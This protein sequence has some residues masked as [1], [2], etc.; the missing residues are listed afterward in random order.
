MLIISVGATAPG[1]FAGDRIAPERNISMIQGELESPQWKILW[2]KAREFVRDENYLFA[3]NAYAQ[4]YSLK[5]NIEEANWEYCKVLLKVDD[6]STA[7]KIVGDLI[8][9][10]PNNSQY[11][12]TGGAVALHWKNYAT[13]I[14]YYGRVLEKDPNGANSDPA[15][16]GLATSL[17]DQG[18]KELAFTLFEQY[19]LRHPENHAVIRTLAD[20]A[21]SLGKDD[22]AR[23]LYSQLLENPSVGDQVIFQAVQVFDGPGY[24]KKRS[25]LWQEYLNRHPDYIPFRQKLAQYYMDAGAFEAALLQVKYLVDNSQNNDHFLLTAG[26]IS[27][28]DLHRPDR[29]LFFYERYLQKHPEDGGVKAKISEIQSILAADFLRI[30]EKEGAEQLWNDLADITLDR[31]AMYLE[32]ADLLEKKGNHEQLIDVLTTLFKHSARDDDI[33]LRLAEQYYRKALYKKT[34]EY[35][36]LV[37]AEKNKSK[38]YY[39]MKGDAEQHLGLEIK[40]LASYERSLAFD[41]H[42]FA[43]REKCLLL[44]GKIGNGNKLKSF[45][46]GGLYQTD[47]G[48]LSRFV[49][50]YLDLL[51]Y[52]F[53][54]EEYARTC[55]WAKERFAGWP[56]ITTRIDLHMAGSLRK[57]GKTKRAEQLLRQLLLGN[58]FVEDVLFQLAEDAVNDK[59]VAGAKSW[60]QELLKTT[61]QRDAKFSYDPHGARLLLVRVEMLQAEGEY[62]EAQQIIDLYLTAAGK[63]STQ[64][65][66][67]P[68]LVALEKKHCWL[69]YYRG[70]VREAYRQC[71][72]LLDNGPFDPELITLK[73]LLLGKLKKTDDGTGVDDKVLIEGT[74]VVSRYLAVALKQMEYREYG[75]ARKYAAAALETYPDSLVGQAVWAELMV[76]TG[77]SQNAVVALSKLIRQYPGE[78]YFQKKRIEVEARRGMYGQGLVLF[79]KEEGGGGIENLAAKLTSSDSTEDLLVLARLLWGDKQQAEAL[80]IYRQLLTPPVQDLLGEKFRQN[81]INYH[82]LS[83]ENSFWNQM[84]LLLRSEPDI[85]AEFMGPQFLLDNRDNEAGKIVSG[86]FEKYSWQ[87]LIASEYT[88]RKAIFDRNYYYAEQSYK[89]LSKQDSS[90]G[91]SDL[92]NIYGKIGK[93]RKEAQVYDAMQKSGTTSPELEKSI[94]RTTLQISPQSVFN[95]EYEE[96]KGRDGH[97]DVARTT[98]GTSFWFTPDLDKDVRIRYTNNRFASL[99]TE[100][101]TGSNYLYTVATY[102]FTKAYELI[103]GGGAEKITGNSNP[104]FQYEVELKGQLDDYVNAYVLLDKKQVYDTIE[105]IQRQITYQSF[106]TGLSIETPVGLSF[107]GDLRHRYYNDGNGENR[108]HGYS[109]Y[110]IFGESLQVAVRYDYQYLI[111]D[112]ENKAPGTVGESMDGLFYWSPSFFTEHRVNLHFQHDFLGY[113]QGEKKGMSYY[114]IDNAIGL[115]DNENLSFTTNFNIF[116][117]MSPHFL[118]K[119][120]FTLSRSDDFEDKGLFLSLH[121]RW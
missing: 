63:L 21:H 71:G 40:A 57:E 9:K 103:L 65:E 64:R 101:S 105:A 29:A 3:V 50:A 78:P 44:A 36:S 118:L 28:D 26:K 51:S 19:S 68:F 60:Y 110:S 83:R 77:T 42:D 46:T 12:L 38:F 115:E 43:L 13:A 30:V 23:K 92:A 18:K 91:M 106:E 17:R 75:A 111:N 84:M 69:S 47:A 74:P 85:I 37:A 54:F 99:D 32:M 121:Y 93:Y 6:Y 96:K 34:V 120:N 116:L 39:L 73:G 25:E 41:P 11:L 62:A 61:G 100:G 15:L 108:F 52:N 119:G 2:D 10:D 97:I 117:E 49:L 45:F 4:L 87:K 31:P 89:R 81:Q 53:L 33:A 27:Q 76:A 80:K 59:N 7:G 98:V 24:E 70:E 86:L 112:D 104:G 113:Q 114:A 107:G 20:D 67:L 5:P 48:V 55:K 56:E 66:L 14:D 58:I 35:L 94:E 102:E 90:E 22:K 1:C 72:S 109:S 95:A 8:D 16:L 82:Y 88:A 79:T